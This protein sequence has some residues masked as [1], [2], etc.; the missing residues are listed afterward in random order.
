MSADLKEDSKAQSTSKDTSAPENMAE[1][2]QILNVKMAF[3]L[4]I[5][6]GLHNVSLR[7]Q[8]LSACASCRE[9]T[10]PRCP[11]SV[12]IIQRIPPPPTVVS[13]GMLNIVSTMVDGTL[14]M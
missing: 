4:G 1:T 6:N 8:E 13:V 14:F 2:F 11:D 12:A 5:G 3:Q 7:P 9:C 10:L